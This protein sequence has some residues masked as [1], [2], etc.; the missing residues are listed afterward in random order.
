MS[1]RS[2]PEPVEVVEEPLLSD[3]E[4]A[5][6]AASVVK[7]AADVEL[8]PEPDGDPTD[9]GVTVEPDDEGPEPR[10]DTLAVPHRNENPWLR[11][12]GGPLLFRRGQFD[13][14]QVAVG[15]PDF[16]QGIQQIEGVTFAALVL[17]LNDQPVV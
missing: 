14:V 3:E 16:P 10:V 8:P 7:A 13:V 6:I 11:P 9:D 4:A 15:D 2:A 12:D 17:A 5:A 1:R